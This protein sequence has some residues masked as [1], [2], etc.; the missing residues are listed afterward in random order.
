MVFDR[1]SYMKKYREKL[2]DSYHYK[3]YIK[4][5][6]KCNSI[7]DKMGFNLEAFTQ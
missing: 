5:R 4:N 1:K 3:K 6:V 2:K 7:L